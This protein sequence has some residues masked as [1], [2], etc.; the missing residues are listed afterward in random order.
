MS[1]YGQG[2]V[3][4]D[5][6]PENQMAAI[7]GPEGLVA[8]L[9]YAPTDEPAFLAVIRKVT[10]VP[11]IPLEDVIAPPHWRFDTDGRGFTV[12]EMQRLT[13]MEKAA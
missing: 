1:E 9:V 13:L 5:R 11:A 3:A 12:V 4:A 8:R 7:V 10:R 2:F 6:R